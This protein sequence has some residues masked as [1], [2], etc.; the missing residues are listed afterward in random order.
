M[1]KTFIF[2]VGNSSRDDLGED[3][4]RNERGGVFF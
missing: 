2:P 1:G 4:C 3:G